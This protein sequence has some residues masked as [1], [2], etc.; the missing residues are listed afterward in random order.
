M[1]IEAPFEFF[2][3]CSGLFIFRNLFNIR[4]SF[5]KISKTLS[6]QIRGIVHYHAIN[7]NPICEEI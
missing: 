2:M 7:A 5:K 3:D 4:M 6:E 1:Y